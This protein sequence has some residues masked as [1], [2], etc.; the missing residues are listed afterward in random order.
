VGQL[1]LSEVLQELYKLCG[2]HHEIYMS[3][4]R[5][6]APDK[7]KTIIRQPFV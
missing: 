7:L 2:K 5:Q 3:D 1:D 6:T 4:P